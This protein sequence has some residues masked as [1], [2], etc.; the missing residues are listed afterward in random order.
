MGGPA[1]RMSEEVSTSG[2]QC[3]I[4]IKITNTDND[5]LVSRQ[6]GEEAPVGGR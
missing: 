2:N 4:I 5:R 3:I 1:C 6:L